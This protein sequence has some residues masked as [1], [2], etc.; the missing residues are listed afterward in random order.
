VVIDDDQEVVYMDW[1][2]P[3]GNCIA[4]ALRGVAQLF[5]AS[6]ALAGALERAGA[7]GAAEC[8]ARRFADARRASE[9]EGRAPPGYGC[10]RDLLL[11]IEQHVL[12]VRARRAALLL[13]GLDGSRWALLRALWLWPQ[14]HMVSTLRCP[15]FWLAHVRAFGIPSAGQTAGR[16]LGCGRARPGA[17]GAGY[18]QYRYTPIMARIAA[19]CAAFAGSALL[20]PSTCAWRSRNA[21]AVCT[22]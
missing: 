3:A 22:G 7:L 17:L 20:E 1:A 6:R 10:M 5:S 9:R 14:N 16:T 15:Q 8:L 18:E 11:A 12:R 13:N 2:T 19:A 4:S 21:S